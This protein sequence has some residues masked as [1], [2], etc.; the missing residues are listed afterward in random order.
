MATLL[1]KPVIRE[2]ADVQ[3][4]GKHAGRP[5]VLE[6]EPPNLIHIRIK[7][8]RQRYTTTVTEVFSYAQRAAREQL[9]RQQLKE[10][11][12]KK[13]LG[14]KKLRKPKKPVF[15]YGSF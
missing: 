7:G 12:E 2:T 3:R 9:Y 15:F 11:H 4:F 6:L 13:K 8:T 1:Q 5:L 10:Y 14:F